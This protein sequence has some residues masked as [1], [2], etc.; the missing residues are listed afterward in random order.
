MKTRLFLVSVFFPYF[1]PIFFIIEKST[2]QYSDLPAAVNLLKNET[3]T[4][5]NEG[6]HLKRTAG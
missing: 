6:T 3:S 2:S 5:I 4:D 1:F